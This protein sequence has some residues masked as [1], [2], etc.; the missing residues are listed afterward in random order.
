MSGVPG[1]GIPDIYFNWLDSGN[2]SF[3]SSLG[4]IDLSSGTLVLD[5]DGADIVAFFIGGENLIP[6]CEFCDGMNLPG[7][8]ALAGASTWTSGYLG[9]TSQWIRTNPLVNRGFIGVIGAGF[10]DGSGT[11]QPWPQD[12][13]P[14]LDFP[15]EG[16]GIANSTTFCTE[17]TF[18]DDDGD[19][20]DVFLAT[21]SSGNY[22][23]NVTGFAPSC[24]PEPGSLVPWL[25]LAVVIVRKRFA[26]GDR[27][28]R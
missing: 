14:V 13:P 27:V 4:R 28:V 19:R 17:Q 16:S 2:L 20:W 1:D 18:Q 6:N 23:T 24:V 5:T 26:G 15:S 8:D 7:A 21:D 12:L 11:E 9:G 22:Y 10:I 25:A 3:Q